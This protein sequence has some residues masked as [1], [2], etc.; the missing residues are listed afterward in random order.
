MTQG[1]D[2]YS[3]DKYTRLKLDKYIESNRA[4][5]RFAGKLVNYKKSLIFL[6]ASDPPPNSPIKIKKHV[7]CPGTRKLIKAFRKRGNCVVIPVDEYN[8]SQTC[9]LCY[10]RFDRRT[11]SHKFKVCQDCR[12]TDRLFLPS[13]IVT[14]M[15]KRDLQAFRKMD[16]QRYADAL[17]ANQ[18]HAVPIDL[19]SKV[20]IY[21]KE[22]QE[23]I[24]GVLK[25]INVENPQAIQKTVWHRDVVAA[26]C[27]MVK[28]KNHIFS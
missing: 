24:D 9:A 28:G 12:P 7:R 10:A 18:A 19:V 22:W 20:Q 16:R 5:D 11:R 21:A 2:V 25:N 17:A 14:Q 13:L 15:G 26:K 6:G 27:I 4:I 3:T 23:N 1:I 8:T